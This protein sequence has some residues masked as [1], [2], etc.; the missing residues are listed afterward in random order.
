MGVEIKNLVKSFGEKQIF[1]GFS[2][3][4]GDTGLYIISGSSGIGKTTLLRMIS[5]LDGRFSGEILRSG[6]CSFAFQEYRLFPTLSALDNVLFTNY[7]KKS[8]EAVS[9]CR[10]MLY[11]MGFL[12]DEL[13]R[14]PSELSGGMKQRVSL[15][16]AFVSDR[17]VLLLDEPTKELD[18]EIARII[19][20]IVKRD[21]AKR[22]VIMVTH[23]PEDIEYLK[24]GDILSAS[25][26]TVIN[27]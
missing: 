6:E 13:S 17:A 15:A 27:I 21:A 5:G 14:L 3:S 22:L 16:R 11:E 18:R 26:V 12:E 23:N 10:T 8:D 2:Y 1:N 24:N 19:L 9:K 7:D 20:D 25:E 4:F